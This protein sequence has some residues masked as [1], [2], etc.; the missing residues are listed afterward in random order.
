MVYEGREFHSIAALV[1]R[2]KNVRGTASK[3]LAPWK[4]VGERSSRLEEEF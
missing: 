1:N 2:K 4:Y 3:I